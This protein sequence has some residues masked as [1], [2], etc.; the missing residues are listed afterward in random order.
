[1]AMPLPLPML[2]MTMMM[3][4]IVVV[5][6]VCC[7]G[8]MQ[9]V[10]LLSLFLLQILDDGGGESAARVEQRSRV[11]A[12]MQSIVPIVILGLGL[13]CLGLHAQYRT[14]SSV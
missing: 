2:L 6:A 10:R 7:V 8:E 12:C 14:C 3:M 13:A 4:M 1:M 11:W 5:A 9:S